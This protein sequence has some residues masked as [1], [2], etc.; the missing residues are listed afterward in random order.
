MHELRFPV[1]DLPMRIV[2]R[3]EDVRDLLGD[4]ARFSSD[5]TVWASEDFK[6]SGLVFGSGTVIERILSVL[7]PPDHTR[8]RKLAMSA[9]TPRRTALWEEP[10]R[11]IVASALDRLEAMESPDVMEFAGTV[12]AEVIGRVLGIPLDKFRQIL[13]AIERAL[14]VDPE[15]MTESTLAY[16][17]IVDYGREI[18][19]EKRRNPGE[20]LTSVFIQARDGDDRLDENE[21]IAMVALMIMVGLD[22]T[23][24]L[25]GSA[26]LAL[27]DH[28]D[29]RKLLAERPELAEAAVEEFL[30]YDGALTVALIR[31]ATQDVE[32]AGS[33]IP[34]GATVVAAL[35]SANRDPEIFENPDQLDITRSG[36]RH[37]GLG[38]GLHNCLGAAL[39][40]LES[41]I[42]IPAFFERYPNARLS[43]PRDEIRYAE[44]WLL[45]SVLALPVDLH[46][47]GPR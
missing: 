12:P 19:E 43:V 28:P 10:T 42:A 23:R 36:P 29:Q 40:R 32:F 20:D 14:H 44:S 30:R 5:A 27:I 45:R 47:S 13:H 46:G 37:L 39:A 1:G 8:V 33:A 2:S 21:L 6:K 25:I 31:F 24:N 16:Q 18:I 7:D 35:Q 22:T 15:H 26:I 9:F 3:Y 11:E 17:E 34:A 41:R 38:H 4:S